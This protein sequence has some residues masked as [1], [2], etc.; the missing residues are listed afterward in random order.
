M[1]SELDEQSLSLMQVYEPSE[2]TPLGSPRTSGKRLVR[3][4][5]RLIQRNILLIGGI[6]LVVAGLTAYLVLSRPLTYEGEFQLLVEPITTA[7]QLP[8][9]TSSSQEGSLAEP[10]LD[11]STLLRVLKS[12]QV[13]ASVLQQIEFRYPISYNQLL[14][15]MKVERIGQDAQ[16]QTKLIRV[17]YTSADQTKILFVLKQLSNGYLKYSLEDRERRVGG[18]AAFIEQQLPDLKQRVKSLESQL[19]TLQ[20][21]ES[22]SDLDSEGAELAKQAR[23]LESQRLETQRNLRAQQKLYVNLQKQLGLAPNQAIAAS[24]LSEDP[25]YQQLLSQLKQ[26][27]T[28]LAQERARFTDANPVIQDLQAKQ[29]NL[30]ALLNQETRQLVSQSQVGNANLGQ[31]P[32]FQNSIQRSLSQRLIDTLNE[33]QV[34]E[35]RSEASTQAAVAVNAR[36]RR[37]PAVKQRYER[38]NRQLASD[39]TRLNQLLLK[40][41]SLKV[42]AAQR[43]IPWQ[44]PTEP[45]LRTDDQGNLVLPEQNRVQKILL[46]VMGGFLLGLG[47]ALLREKHR[48]AFLSVDDLQDRTQLPV[49]G[50]L[51]F[52]HAIEAIDQNPNRSEFSEASVTNHQNQAFLQA[53]EAL[54]TKIRFLAVEPPVRSL[55]ISSVAA[56]DGKTTVAL[57]L[58]QSAARMG[59]RVLLVDANPAFPQLH[60]RLGL[61]NFEGLSD[62]LE[63]NLDPNQLIQRVPY[64]KNLFLLT[65]GLATKVA[66]K[67]SASNQ[68]KYLMEQLNSTFDL[69]I[70]DTPYL[71][72]HA[73]ANFL[74]L[75]TDGLVLVVGM[76]KTQQSNLLKTVKD[77]K[78]SRLPILGLVSNFSGE[79]ADNTPNEEYF[80]GDYFETPEVEDEFEIFRAT[81]RESE[82]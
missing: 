19:Q 20:Q 18:G 71:Q 11:Y 44:I 25:R 59:Q 48:D 33:I 49:L 73:D 56:R 47:A 21:Q 74:T 35:I 62:I 34:L 22:I 15:D 45:Q 68:M 1:K 60:S 16:N 10:G 81:S 53:A 17:S 55:V 24:S 51:P 12:P 50:N 41:E 80:G 30:K 46:G 75:N 63:R 28:Q 69:V 32:Q 61:P 72:G 40:R 9:P 70:Y 23:E 5:W 64:Q 79:Q 43:D 31:L 78:A 67:S 36:L 4:L 26:V 39:T 29:S 66:N 13:L 2:Y 65:A 27:E 82:P 58:A 3:P 14:Q 38:L 37:F 8:D 6:N 54:Y 7:G 52:N 77:L 57:Y 42:E 76:G